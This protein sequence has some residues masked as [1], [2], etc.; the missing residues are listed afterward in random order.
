MT[1]AQLPPDDGPDDGRTVG[2]YEAKT[3]LPRLLKRVEAGETITI[4]KHG[5]PIAQ[6]I[7]YREERRRHDPDDVLQVFREHRARMLATPG[8]VPPT[9]DE[10]REWIAEGRA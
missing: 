1:A 6:L 8:Y 7:P 9:D 10:I 2:V 5:H 3:Q 4:T